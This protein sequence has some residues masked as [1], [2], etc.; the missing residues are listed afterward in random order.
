[1]FKLIVRQ[2]SQ[3]IFDLVTD[4]FKLKDEQKKYASWKSRIEGVGS[5]N[6]SKKKNVGMDGAN[7]FG[8]TSSNNY[9]GTISAYYDRNDIFGT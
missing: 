1:M 7:A 4:S 9:G 5:S 8:A 6:T 2:K 3:Y